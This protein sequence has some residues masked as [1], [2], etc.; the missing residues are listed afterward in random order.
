M[1]KEIIEEKVNQALGK[2]SG[3]FMR[4]ECKGVEIVMPTE[5]LLEISNELVSFIGQ[6]QEENEKL[7]EALIWCSGSEDFQYPEGKAREGWE[8]IV[9]PLLN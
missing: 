5:E 3:L 4:E 1:K 2:T 7:K 8:K 6:I 9:K